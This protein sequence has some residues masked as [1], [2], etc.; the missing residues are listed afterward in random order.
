MVKIS[1]QFTR[2][3]V[4]VELYG[5]IMAATSSSGLGTSLVSQVTMAAL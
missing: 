4:L 2:S 3:H 1:Y 5:I